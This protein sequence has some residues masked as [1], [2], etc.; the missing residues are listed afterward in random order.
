MIEFRI[1]GRMEL[2]GSGAGASEPSALLSQ[3][4][5]TALF[6]F[7]LLDRPGAMQ[8][9]DRLAAML[10]PESDQKRARGALSQTLYVIRRHLGPDVLVTRGTEDVG[11]AP[12]AVRC[13]ALEFQHLLD[14]GERESALALYG[15][16]LL[17]AFYVSNAPGFEHWLATEQA[18]LRRGARLAARALANAAEAAG[19][20]AAAG[21]WSRWAARV[22]PL[23]EAAL[24]RTMESLERMGDRSGALAEFEHYRKRLRAEA[25]LEPESETSEL[26]ARIASAARRGEGPAVPARAP[27][28]PAGLAPDAGT[29]EPAAH[30]RA[31]V[32]RSGGAVVAFVL[33]VAAITLIARL[34]RASSPEPAAGSEVPAIAVVPLSGDSA[35]SE[36]TTRGVIDWLQQAGLR[37]QGWLSVQRFIGAPDIIDVLRDVLGV[38]YVVQASVSPA[39]PG[40]V[41]AMSLI[42]TRNGVQVWSETVPGTLHDLSELE[43]RAASTVAATVADREGREPEH[44]RIA[45]YTQNPVADSLY[46]SVLQRTSDTYN[47]DSLQR[48]T[49]DLRRAIDAD[50]G[51]APAYVELASALLQQTR[52]YWDVDPRDQRSEALELLDDARDIAPGLASTYTT[53]GWYYYGFGHDYEKSIR[54]HLTAIRKAPY[55]PLAWTGYAFPL[56]ATGQVDSAL[57]VVRHARELERMNPLVVSTQCW[58]E[59][60]ANRLEEALDTCTFL[61]EHIDSTYDVALDIENLVSTLL[62]V[63]HGDTAGLA[64]RRRQFEAD[65]ASV[66]E[67]DLNFEHGRAFYWASVGDTARALAILDEEKAIPGIRALRIANGYATVGML[68]SAFVWLDRAIE[69]QDPFLPEITVRPVMEPFRRDPRYPD[70]LRRLGLDRYFPDARR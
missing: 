11:I 31:R 15:G 6:A 21:R 36:Q 33:L 44:Y 68:D 63:R 10:W 8:R 20:T 60:L 34:L 57:A 25:D 13:N 29:S 12:D 30:R 22:D 4:K 70:V 66:G 61:T 14:A 28:A 2:S 5:P 9:R 40:L 7:L 17:P 50:P 48:M 42:D 55:Q 56:I 39:E 65:P 67:Q 47:P 58:F 27:L 46:R 59:Y 62:M 69:Q 37:T 64:Q 41:L 51:F 54:N 19:D 43:F 24:R 3:P 35:L 49:D 38:E 53:L 23:D 16:E 32:R 45:R 18:R 1:L 26:A 52:N